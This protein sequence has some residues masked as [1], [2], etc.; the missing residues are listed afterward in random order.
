[1]DSEKVDESNKLGHI[2]NRPV[3]GS[4]RVR[5]IETM[6]GNCVT[7]YVINVCPCGTNMTGLDQF[8]KHYSECEEIRGFVAFLGM[9]NQQQTTSGNSRQNPT[10]S[11]QENI[12]PEHGTTK[13]RKNTLGILEGTQSS[14]CTN[15][16]Y[17]SNSRNFVQKRTVAVSRSER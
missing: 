7:P 17:E 3:G 8:T 10:L 5:N 9:Y 6:K 14:N 12:R 16:S 13:R 2:A 1:M 15:T 11:Y 4:I